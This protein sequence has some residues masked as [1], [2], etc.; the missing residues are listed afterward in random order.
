[1]KQKIVLLILSFSLVPVIGCGAPRENLSYVEEQNSEE[2]ILLDEKPK[3]ES[4]DA[5]SVYVSLQGCV[6]EPGVYIVP[7]GSRVYEVINLAGG[8]TDLA[9]MSAINLVDIIQDGMKLY[10]PKLSTENE[11]NSYNDQYSQMVNINTASL[12]ELC[13]L[14][15]IGETRAK[16]I[17]A[18]REKHGSFNKIEDIKNVSGIK[19]GTFEKIKDNIRVY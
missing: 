1:M 3:E 6:N 5:S 4:L 19:E 17:I 15:G 10:V 18:Y 7:K 8:T 2:S 11:E 13:T 12:N 9:D 16:A 14:S